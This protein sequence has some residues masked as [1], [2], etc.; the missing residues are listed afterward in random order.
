MRC[1]TIGA[2]LTNGIL[3]ASIKSLSALE[4]FIDVSRDLMRQSSKSASEKSVQYLLDCIAFDMQKSDKYE[5]NSCELEHQSREGASDANRCA[6]E[7]L[8]DISSALAYTA[9]EA[10][11]AASS[12]P[13]RQVGVVRLAVRALLLS[14]VEACRKVEEAAKGELA[15][16]EALVSAAR[17][18]LRSEL[19][20]KTGPMAELLVLKVEA[21]VLFA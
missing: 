10:L 19:V 5:F 6:M 13:K 3:D 21:R 8:C 15:S 17:V 7:I 16:R 14:G 12:L 1:L 4:C 11:G 20:R 18:A 9:A 2:T